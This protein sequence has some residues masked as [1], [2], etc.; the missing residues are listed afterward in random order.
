M[1]RRQDNKMYHLSFMLSIYHIY[2]IYYII[3][4]HQAKLATDYIYIKTNDI[5]YY[6]GQETVEAR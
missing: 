3:I 1:K 5:L 4:D 6:L 2:I